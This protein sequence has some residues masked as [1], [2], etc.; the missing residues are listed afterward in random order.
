MWKQ[1][2]PQRLSLD[3]AMMAL[4]AKPLSKLLPLANGYRPTAQVHMANDVV[5]VMARGCKH[6]TGFSRHG[7]TNAL[8]GPWEHGCQGFTRTSHWWQAAVAKE[9]IWQ[10]AW[11]EEE[12]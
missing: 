9:W 12:F 10:G 4:M 1:L 2:G 3:V 7:H 8:W 6:M 11:A 5:M